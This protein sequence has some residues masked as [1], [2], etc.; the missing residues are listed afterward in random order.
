MVDGSLPLDR[1]VLLLIEKIISALL[2]VTLLLVLA[3]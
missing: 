3:P 2:I 1:T